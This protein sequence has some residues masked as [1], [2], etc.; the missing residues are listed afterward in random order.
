MSSVGGGSSLTNMALFRAPV[1]P[2]LTSLT[3]L[4]VPSHLVYPCFLSS[5]DCE[6]LEVKECVLSKCH[7]I[8]VCRYMDI[9]CTPMCQGHCVL[10]PVMVG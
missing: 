7:Q 3:V 1:T 10:L 6:L 4:S 2:T 9:Y 8:D 5:L